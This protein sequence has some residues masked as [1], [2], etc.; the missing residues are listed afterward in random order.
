[1]T[2]SQKMRV[3]RFENKLKQ[4][5][6]AKKLGISQQVYSL[7]ESEYHKPKI[8]FILL[9]KKVTGIELT[10]D[11]KEADKASSIVWKRN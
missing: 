1:M 4:S 3:Y 6:I 2:Y 7:I 10:D 11:V 5:D 8:D 9:Y